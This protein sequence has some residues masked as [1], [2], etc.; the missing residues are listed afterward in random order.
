MPTLALIHP[1]S[2]LQ[3]SQNLPTK[4]KIQ[5]TNVTP[6][7]ELYTCEHKL[8]LIIKVTVKMVKISQLVIGLLAVGSASAFSPSPAVVSKTQTFGHSIHVLRQ[9]FL[10]LS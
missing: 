10:D 2:D 4:S 7:S 3:N 9:K 8:I 6:K 5:Y 1:K